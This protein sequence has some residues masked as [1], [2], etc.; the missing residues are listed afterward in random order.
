VRLP[1]T[2]GGIVLATGV[3]T[4]AQ[5]LSANDALRLHTMLRDVSDAVKKNYYD[6]TYHGLNWDVRFREYDEKL[7][8]AP[9]L[10]G[11]LTMIAAFLDGLKDSHTYFSP[12]PRP[13]RLDYGYRL[14][15]I[16]DQILVV[17]S[18]S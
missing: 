11:G 8:S 15:P 10:N 17:Q 2:I 14:A 9:S 3:L 13:Y 5:S 1:L 16:G 7:K 4:S 12:P 6:S 18:L